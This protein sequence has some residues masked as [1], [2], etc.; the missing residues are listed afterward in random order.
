MLKVGGALVIHH[1]HCCN[2]MSD[3][4]STAA[5]SE[6]KTSRWVLLKTFSYGLITG[7]VCLRAVRFYQKWRLPKTHKIQSAVLPMLRANTEVRAHIGTSLKPGLLSTYAYTGGIQWRLPYMDKERK[8]TSLI[9]VT[10]EPW[11]VQ[12]LFQVLGE[13]GAG[14]VSLETESASSRG[15]GDGNPVS[16]LKWLVVDFNDGQRLIMKDMTAGQRESAIEYK[17]LNDEQK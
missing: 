11:S 17:H 1:C 12:M 4:T 10:Y 5:T 16:T 8:W 7:L 2:N 13:K 3:S 9:P 14:L 6:V 15:R